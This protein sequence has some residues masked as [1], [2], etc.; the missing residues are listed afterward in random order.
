[1]V[2]GEGFLRHGRRRRR[3]AQGH[4]LVGQHPVEILAHA[5][6]LASD[7]LQL[8]VAKRG[9]AAVGQGDPAVDVARL[10]VARDG[11]NVVGVP[12]QLA[13]QIRRFDTMPR[14]AA[15]VERPDERRAR[16]EGV[17]QLGKSNVI[18]VKARD[19]LAVDSPDRLVVVAQQ[20]RCDLF[21]GRGAPCL[22]HAHERH[23]A[24][25]VLAQQLFG[26]QEIVFVVLFQHAHARRLGERAE[27]HGR[28]VDG[29][30]DVHEAQVERALRHVER[31]HIADQ[32]DIRVVHGHVE[33]DLIVERGRALG[34]VARLNQPAARRRREA[35]AA[36]SIGGTLTRPLMANIANVAHTTTA[37]NSLTIDG[38]FDLSRVPMPRAVRG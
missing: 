33:I 8:R 15:V 27:M 28:R 30:S 16:E 14:G 7:E 17:G 13:R 29:R 24:A 11:E 37:R 26:L 35:A 31:A 10:V 22:A 5:V 20:V 2:V 21:L 25:D 36:A 3:G 38:S 19:D 12:R 4:R 32:R 34:R 1:M 9:A 18:G 23:V 6:Q